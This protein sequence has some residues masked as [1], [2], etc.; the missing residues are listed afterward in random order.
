MGGDNMQQY[1][2]DKIENNQALITGQDAHHIKNVMRCN[3]GDNFRVCNRGTCYFGTIEELTKTA[4]LVF[5]GEAYQSTELKIKVD[6]AQSLIKREKFELMIQK[7]SE[8]GV[9]NIVPIKAKNSVVKIN[10]NKEDSKI[11]RWNTIA[12]EA[13]EQS[14][15]SRKASVES[16]K[17]LKEVDYT[18]YD[19]V[20]VLY[21][22]E[23]N[24]QLSF[25]NVL[26]DKVLVVIGPEGGFAKEEIEYLD[27]LEN[28]EVVSLGN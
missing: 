24:K 13:C 4:V 3:I 25:D 27:S 22:R 9:R 6:I 1:F 21:A 16:P 28:S 26:F 2:V 8:L 5:L 10:S 15:R 23:D 17:T 11:K 14:E 12:K 20:Y 18:L 19:K 7:S